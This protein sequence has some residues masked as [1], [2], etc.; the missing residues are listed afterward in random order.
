M[1]RVGTKCVF[2]GVS[3]IEK[4]ILNANIMRYFHFKS[5]FKKKFQSPISSSVRGPAWLNE[6][7]RWI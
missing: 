2:S 7:G 4:V 3:F 5:L 6:L 1:R